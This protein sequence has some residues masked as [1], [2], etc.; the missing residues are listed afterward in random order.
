MC[1][2][3]TIMLGLVTHGPTNAGL[4]VRLPSFLQRIGKSDSGARLTDE[5]P[6]DASVLVGR[7]AIDFLRP[8]KRH[9]QSASPSSDIIANQ[10]RCGGLQGLPG[11]ASPYFSFDPIAT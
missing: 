10:R 1:C 8:A 2:P 11:W 4:N 7:A 5:L 9:H 6:P 3:L